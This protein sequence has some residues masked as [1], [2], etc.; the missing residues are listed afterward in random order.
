MSEFLT[1]TFDP[2]E[3]RGDVIRRFGYDAREVA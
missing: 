1:C 2:H 3:L